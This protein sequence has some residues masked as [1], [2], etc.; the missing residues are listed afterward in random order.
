MREK[1]QPN[2]FIFWFRWT[3]FFFSFFWFLQLLKLEKKRRTSIDRR[4]KWAEMRWE[5][6][7]FFFAVCF[8]TL[9]LL[10]MLLFVLSSTTTT[11]EKNEMIL[12]CAKNCIFFSHSLYKEWEERKNLVFFSFSCCSTQMS[13]ARIS[14]ASI[15]LA[16]FWAP[17][18]NTF[19]LG[20]KREREKKEHQKKK[21]I[22]EATTASNEMT[23]YLRKQQVRYF[24]PSR[25]AFFFLSLFNLKLSV[26]QRNS[27]H[28]QN[29][30]TVNSQAAPTFA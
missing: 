8:L 3:W 19:K 24:F 11:S 12:S 23:K 13:N 14:Q 2:S 22:S 25:C 15:A 27:C 26:E 20:R 17:T 21:Q 28:N 4:R 9:L 10:A 7:F 5:A 6:N 30:C 16:D 1:N 18:S 29:S